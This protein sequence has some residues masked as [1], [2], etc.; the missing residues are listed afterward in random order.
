MRVSE[1]PNVSLND[2]G[3]VW[4]DIH[5]WN[6]DFEECLLEVAGFWP[7]YSCQSKTVKQQASPGIR[8]KCGALYRLESMFLEK[9]Q[10]D[11]RMDVIFADARMTASLRML[12]GMRWKVFRRCQKSMLLTSSP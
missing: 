2:A 9:L 10:C 12:H 5:P 8:Y 1:A 6:A 7:L 3:E 11:A 4:E